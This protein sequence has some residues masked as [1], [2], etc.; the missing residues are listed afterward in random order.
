MCL[1]SIT[2]CSLADRLAHTVERAGLV[3]V[4][5]PRFFVTGTPFRSAFVS[6][7]RHPSAAARIQGNLGALALLGRR[8]HRVRTTPLGVMLQQIPAGC[9]VHNEGVEVINKEKTKP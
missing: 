3:S 5:V 4:E 9:G 7:A 6:F 8:Y 2:C 1:G